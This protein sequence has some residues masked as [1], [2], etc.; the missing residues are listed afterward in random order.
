MGSDATAFFWVVLALAVYMAP[1][2][3]AGFRNHPNTAAITVLDLLL[4]WTFLGW[5]VALVWSLTANT[6]GEPG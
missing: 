5:V 1:A 4:G 2:F 3:V 6:E